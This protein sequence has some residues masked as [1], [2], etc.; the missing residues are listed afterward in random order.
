MSN[1]N[2]PWRFPDC[3][4]IS[5]DQ[6]FRDRL[7][8]AVSPQ[9]TDT[10]NPAC[11]RPLTFMVPPQNCCTNKI[12]I[13]SQQ[14][15]AYCLIAQ[16]TGGRAGITHCTAKRPLRTNFLLALAEQSKSLV[17]MVMSKDMWFPT[18]S[19]RWKLKLV[20]INSGRDRCVHTM[21]VMRVL[22]RVLTLPAIQL[23]HSTK[24]NFDQ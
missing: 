6:V 19:S 23:P 8:P 11:S 9:N 18:L 3:T 15:T 2:K 16:A 7:S 20:L 4:T 17:P 10:T 1:N 22:I 24:A 14:E 5:G 21:S 13:L 12:I